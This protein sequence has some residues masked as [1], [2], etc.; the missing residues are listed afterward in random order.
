MLGHQPAV[1]LV[2]FSS[3]K[4]PSLERIVSLPTSNP[5]LKFGTIVYLHGHKNLRYVTSHYKEIISTTI[6]SGWGFVSP[7]AGELAQLLDVISWVRDQTW[8]NRIVIGLGLKFFE[9]LDHLKATGRDPMLGP[10]YLFYFN[11]TPEQWWHSANQSEVV[12]LNRLLAQVQKSI[13]I[14]T[15]PRWG[16][17]DLLMNWLRSLNPDFLEVRHSYPEY[18]TPIYTISGWMNSRVFDAIYMLDTSVMTVIGP[19][20]NI[21]TKTLKTALRDWIAFTQRPTSSSKRSGSR[22][23]IYVIPTPSSRWYEGYYSLVPPIRLQSHAIKYSVSEPPDS[24][25]DL[26]QHQQDKSIGRATYKWRKISL[27]WG[28]VNGC[29][30]MSVNSNLPQLRREMQ[31]SRSGWEGVIQLEGRVG[32]WGSP[33]LRMRVGSPSSSPRQFSR[34]PPTRPIQP[35]PTTRPQVPFSVSPTPMTTRPAPPPGVGPNSML[36]HSRDLE[37]AVSAPPTLKPENYC[38]CAQLYTSRGELVSYGYCYPKYPGRIDLSLRPF[39]LPPII[40]ATESGDHT[41]RTADSNPLLQALEIVSDPHLHSLHLFLTQSW[42]PTVGPGNNQTIMLL[43]DV[44]LELPLIVKEDC[45]RSNILVPDEDIQIRHSQYAVKLENQALNYEIKTHEST[46]TEGTKSGT[47][48]ASFDP[49]GDG[50]I[51]LEDHWNSDW[52][53]RKIQIL[54]GKVISIGLAS[55]RFV[56][57]QLPSVSEAPGSNPD[58]DPEGPSPLS[59]VTSELPSIDPSI[60]P[61]SVSLQLSPRATE[62]KSMPHENE[63][64]VSFSLASTVSASSSESERSGVRQ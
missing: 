13:I 35:P 26:V 59:P 8:S 16:S 37:S 40:G 17:G 14:D 4:T 24:L 64:E 55:S 49:S 18:A 63:S 23:G 44:I 56:G 50:Q 29:V 15:E 32:I 2:T 33:R 9:L 38:L 3:I 61:N 60:V 52:L 42:L 46:S 22:G 53:K 54:H 34:T 7:V 21:S 11:D 10:D 45:K 20:R 25:L 36:P 27:P 41:S 39:F 28:L 19:W 51:I 31:D 58:L 1:G 5:G 30:E 48:Q 62:S 12:D 6:K 43:R 47:L 57:T